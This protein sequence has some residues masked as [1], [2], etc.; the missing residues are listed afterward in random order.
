MKKAYKILALTD[1]RKHSKE[2][3]IYSLLSEMSIHPRCEK[4]DVASRGIKDNNG[5]FYG[6]NST[7]LKVS[8]V[9]TDFQYDINA[10][11]YDDKALSDISEYD[12][13]LLRLPRP[14]EDSFLRWLKKV[15]VGKIIIND[16]IGILETSNK[17]FLQHFPELCPPM[18]I[19]QSVEEVIEM[20][21]LYPIV[22]KPLKEYGGRGLLKIEKKI[23]NDG[24]RN[25]DL[26]SYLSTIEN[27][28]NEENYLGMKYLKNV[29]QGDKRIL[30]VNGEILA[31][32]LR[33]PP[34]DTW[35]CNVARGGTSMPTEVDESEKD[36]VEKINPVLKNRGI[37]IYGVD[38]L[39]D[40]N[41]KRVLS[42]INT[43]SIGGFLQAESQTG[44]PIIRETI[45]KII[46]HVDEYII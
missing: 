7:T 13:I 11:S 16:P 29:S 19:L 10:R 38:T 5:F 2:N 46:A 25:Y 24:D 15:C 4:I 34:Q 21:S 9:S 33:L 39:V 27:Y 12:V 41:N 28:L 43:L 30:V 17:S 45:D 23:V 42:E 31:A 40:D 26:K 8:H 20:S 1:H 6:M 22:L 32:S 18:K 14:V 36:I 3:S 37:L 44:K 35:L